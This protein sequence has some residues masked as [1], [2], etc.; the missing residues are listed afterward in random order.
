MD[1]GKWVVAWMVVISSVFNGSWESEDHSKR[2]SSRSLYCSIPRIKWGPVW[3]TTEISE[4]PRCGLSCQLT[5]NSYRIASG[6]LRSPLRSQTWLE[7]PPLTS[8]FDD[9]F[10][11]ITLQFASGISRHQHHC[12]HLQ[13]SRTMPKS[14]PSLQPS[15]QPLRPKTWGF[16]RWGQWNFPQRP[17]AFFSDQVSRHKNRS[18]GPYERLM[19]W[20]AMGYISSIYD[21]YW[22]ILIYLSRL[23]WN[24]F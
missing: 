16:R 3:S 20:L 15:L 23:G 7:N 24:I 21:I 22:I 19:L 10:A 4:S 14:Q 13:H 17:P 8:M 11:A 5:T 18:S 2:L 6:C 1:A 9:D 12:Q